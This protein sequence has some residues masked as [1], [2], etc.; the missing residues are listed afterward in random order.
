MGDLLSDVFDPIGANSRVVKQGGTLGTRVA[1][2]EPF[3]AIEQDVMGERYL[4]DWK[5]ALDHA[6]VRAE[7]LDAVAHDRR[8]G[9]GQFFRADRPRPGMPFEAHPGHSDT[10]Q[11]DVDVGALRHLGDTASPSRQYLLVPVCVR[12]DPR[13]AA[14]MVQD[15]GQTGHSLRKGGQLGQL[16]ETY[17]DVER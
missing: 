4:V 17:S 2:G 12:A 7:L 10:A 6:P 15:D 8:H 13:Q 9:G 1:L 11:L 16:W 3:E 14:K 5:V